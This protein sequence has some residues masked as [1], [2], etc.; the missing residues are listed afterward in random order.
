MSDYAQI[1]IPYTDKQGNK[2]I[3]VMKL[4]KSDLPLFEGLN[5]YVMQSSNSHYIACAKTTP[6]KI[7]REQFQAH[8]SIA[9]FPCGKIVHHINND[10]LDNRSSNLM[11]L[12]QKEHRQLHCAI[13]RERRNLHGNDTHERRKTGGRRKK[14]ESGQQQQD[15]FSQSQ[16]EI[17]FHAG[18]VNP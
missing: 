8:R 10:G 6:G 18:S 9:G 11:I 7:G 13:N 12:T 3:A 2:C 17:I 5:L 14:T 4:D 15:V 16:R 1:E